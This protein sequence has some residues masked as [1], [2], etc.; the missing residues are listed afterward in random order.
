MCSAAAGFPLPSAAGVSCLEGPCGGSSWQHRFHS[1]TAAQ[2][3]AACRWLPFA[4]CIGC[5][6]MVDCVCLAAFRG[7]HLLV[8]RAWRGLAGEAVGSIGF[9]AAQLRKQVCFHTYTGSITRDFVPQCVLWRYSTLS[10]WKKHMPLVI[11]TLEGPCREGVQSAGFTAAQLRKQVTHQQLARSVAFLCLCLPV[12][13]HLRSSGCPLSCDVSVA[14]DGVCWT[15]GVSRLEGPCRE[16][17]GSIGFTAA[18]L[19]KQVCLYRRWLDCLLQV[20][21]A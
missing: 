5:D 19:R 4:G 17:V 11:F 3:G 1:S 2:A 20:S 10:G 6:C 18:Q 14:C 15:G 8:R 7:F 12:C 21:S 16:A 9:T 13:C